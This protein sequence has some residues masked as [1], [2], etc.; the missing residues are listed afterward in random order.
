[1]ARGKLRIYLGA[2]PGVGKTF[3]MLDEGW[4]RRSRGTDVVVGFVEAHGRAKTLAQIRDLP[5]VP[6]RT[7]S[8]RGQML[9]EMDVDAILARRPAVALVDELAHTNVPGSRNEKRWQDIDELLDAGIDVISTV[10][11]QHLVSVNDVV[12]RITGVVQRETVPDAVVRAA[13]QIELV[14]M[15]PEALRRRMAHGNIYAPERIDTALA[16]YFRAGNLSALRE[17]ALLWVAD[18]VDEELAAYRERHDISAPWET[19]ERIVVALSGAPGGENL[20]RRAARM[21]ARSNGEV[22]GVHVRASDGLVRPEPAGLEAQ[23][24]LLGELNG[25]YAEVSGMDEAKALVEFARAENATQL[26]MGASSR[27]RLQEVLHG[28]VINRTIRAAAPIDVHVI[29]SPEQV[30]LGLPPLAQ[31]HR[32]AS[33]PPRR[34]NLALVLATAGIVVVGAALS[35]LHS[36][37][38]LPGALLCLLLGVVAVTMVGGAVPAALSTLV[39]AVTADY[40]FTPPIHSLRIAHP[41]DIVAL[42][43]FCAVAGLVA[44]LVDRLARRNLQVVR[45]RAETEA[46]ARLAGRAVLSGADALPDIVNELRRT[47]DLESVAIL[48][49]DGS[50]WRTVTAAGAP[51]PVAPE[52]AAFS[53][54][55]DE[56][57]VL[58]LTGRPLSAEDTRLLNAFVS[59]LRMTQERLVLES[60]AAQA[61]DLAE[62]NSLRSALLAAVSHDLRTPLASIKAAVTSMTSSEVEWSH[63]DVRGFCKTIEDETDR[64][65]GLVA[66]LLDMGRLQTGILP[67]ALEAVSVEEVVDRALASLSTAAAGVVLNFPGPLPLI[68]ADPGLLERAVANVVANAQKW[69]PP[70]TSARI[71][72]G[73]AGDRVDVRV[74][75]TGPGIPRD[76]RADVF[77][78]FQQLGDAARDWR[79]GV[80]LGLA[81]AK[82]FTEAMGGSLDIEDTPGGGTTMVFRLPIDSGA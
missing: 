23:R 82:G 25:R 64:L 66:N 74:I 46:L 58:V 42:V 7:V 81:V 40:F 26:F 47:F 12:E 56:G 5:V 57:S 22:L 75:D 29:S 52:Q 79:R 63:E 80:G 31:R 2:A 72:V 77:L 49:P 50:R 19:K 73:V 44:Q 54:E 51:V 37:L 35:P 59:Q 78:P 76:R 32:P 13:D 41:A 8:Y 10:N 27:S 17:L 70:G 43:V 67:V 20:L 24:R 4:R 48:A 34:R 69:S 21:A 1:M 3:A 16:N 15:A 9:E 18:R 65:T 45:A 30:A 14:D 62:A 39:A 71:E 53:A 11:V 33:V 38:G 36:S 68:R 6:R 60:E 61:A 28:S 55:L